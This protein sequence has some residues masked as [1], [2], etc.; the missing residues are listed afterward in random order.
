[1]KEFRSKQIQQQVLLQE[2]ITEI[3]SVKGI[4]NI[5]RTLVKPYGFELCWNLNGFLLHK[6]LHSLPPFD[7]CPAEILPKGHRT[8]KISV[9][10]YGFEEFV[11]S[12]T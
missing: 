8:S 10:P 12:S 6:V 9:Q 3:K 4:K 5:E 7:S 1:M 2:R 11:L